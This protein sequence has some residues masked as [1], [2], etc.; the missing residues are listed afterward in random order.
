MGETRDRLG[1]TI[2]QSAHSRTKPK[3]GG[4]VSGDYGTKKLSGAMTARSHRDG[5]DMFFGIAEGTG[6]CSVGSRITASAKAL[7]AAQQN[8]GSATAR[9]GCTAAKADASSTNVAEWLRQVKELEEQLQAKI[10][11]G[12]PTCPEGT[13]QLPQASQFT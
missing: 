11:Q 1:S 5:F 9:V 2:G 8:Q 6:N 12:P 10:A 3:D 13:D 4:R 7:N